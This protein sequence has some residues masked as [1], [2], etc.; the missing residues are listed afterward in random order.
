MI[1]VPDATIMIPESVGIFADQAGVTCEMAEGFCQSGACSPETCTAFSLGVSKPCGCTPGT[2]MG[3]DDLDTDA[4]FP[5]CNIC[6]ST[7]FIV[8]NNDAMITV[9]DGVD[10]PG[11][12]DVV[13]NMEVDCGFVEEKCQNGFCSKKACKGFSTDATKASCGCTLTSSSVGGGVSGD[14]DGIVPSDGSNNNSNN[15]GGNGGAAAMQQC[16][17]CG[18]LTVSNNDAMITIPD[19]VYL[20][21]VENMEA[22][23]GF[24]EEQCQTGFCNPETCKKLDTD[25]TKEACGCTSGDIEI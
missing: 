7:D 20:P 9:P 15:N 24:V 10:L 13:R 17:I 6:G 18:S 16:S 5:Q 14:Q 3:Q 19:S 2:E 8:T 4:V 22:T 12:E 21:G 25:T 1:S 23:C 11:M